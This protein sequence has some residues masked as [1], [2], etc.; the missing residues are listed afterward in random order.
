MKNFFAIKKRPSLGLAPAQQRKLWLAQ[1]LKAFFVVFFVYAT[2]YLIRSNFKAAQPLLKE[3]Y[4]LTTLELGTIGLA[5]SLTYAFGK[6]ALGYIIDGRNTK[7]IISFLLVVASL[8]VL[9]I[10][11]VLATFGSVISIFVVLWGLNGLFQSIGGPA[12]C[13]TVYRWVP[14]NRRSTTMG[15]WNMSHNIGGA[16]AGILALW[17]ARTFFHG[18]VVGM[19]VFPAVIGLIIGICGMFIGKDDPQELGWDRCERIFEEPIEQ[20]NIAAESMS[21]WEIFKKFTISNPWIWI[22]CTANVFI[23]IVRIGVDNWAPLYVTESLGWSADNAV[24]TLFYFETGALIGTPLWG[25]IADWFKGR[26]AAVGAAATVAIFIPLYFYATG[27]STLAV[28][29][30]LFFMGLLLFAPQLLI[31]LSVVGLVPKKGL[32]VANGMVGTFGYLFGDSLAKVG[33][34]AIADPE[35]S[36]L[37]LFGYLLHGWDAVFKI[38][39]VAGVGAIILLTIVAVVEEKKIRNLEKEKLAGHLA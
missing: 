14:R 27:S 28:N 21:K 12:S 10:G 39:A 23:Y 22:L 5:F 32:S 7:R 36:G 18:S 19:F 30:A 6:M 35:Q 1:F 24:T 31:P 15:F 17:G 20:E 8:A 2:M 33:L 38:L 37:S 4:G 34:A 25:L 26:N 11:L 29:T 3:Q 13:N 16:L 9:I